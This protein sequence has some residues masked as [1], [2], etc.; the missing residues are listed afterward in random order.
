M[1]KKRDYPVPPSLRARDVLARRPNG[2]LSLVENAHRAHYP[3]A[4]WPVGAGFRPVYMVFD[5]DA[6][7]HML[8]KNR[9]N[10]TKSK[11]LARAEAVLGDGIL[12]SD[13][14]KWKRNRRLMTPAFHGRAL[15]QYLEDMQRATR[16]VLGKWEPGVIT[17]VHPLM[18]D[19]ALDIAVSTLFGQDIGDRAQ[20]VSDAL[21][22]VLRYFTRVVG[23]PMY[24][25]IWAPIPSM[26][27]ARDAIAVLD[28]V[29]YS[30]IR[31]RRR[32][33]EQREDALGLLLAS[34]YEDGTAMS[35]VELRDEVMTLLLAGHETTAQAMTFL[36]HLLGHYPEAQ[37]AA[38][39]ECAEPIESAR[40][41]RDLEVLGGC[42]R[43]A[44]RI[45]PPAPFVARD[46]LGDDEL[47]GF[48]IP[49]GAQVATAP[50][51]VQRDAR[52]WPDPMR[53]DPTRWTSEIE[54]PRFTYFPFGGGQRQCIGAAFAHME[55]VVAAHELL[56][57]FR[58]ESLGPLEV[59]V[60]QS[61]TVRPAVPLGLRLEAL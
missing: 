55:A 19:L 46:A 42:V 54:R 58:V 25:P 61:M 2:V 59:P 12:M 13:G 34:R 7:E 33:G 41:I 36:F 16:A 53:F 29:V 8:V 30:I 21:L 4:Y 18:M 17:D 24:V 1:L 28:G 32:T 3:I 50:W 47:L 35:D 57:R 31:D 40:Q 56:T 6:I 45:Y 39:A 52:F 22:V 11:A 10:Y 49:K 38:R 60:I 51:C 9:D 27:R 37:E 20:S 44:L 26:K 43:E 15:E 5:P 23:K 48:K 14:P